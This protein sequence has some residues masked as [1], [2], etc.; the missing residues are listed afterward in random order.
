MKL[1]SLSLTLYKMRFYL[2][3]TIG[4]GR[5]CRIPYVPGL[6]R[7]LGVASGSALGAGCRARHASSTHTG[8]RRSDVDIGISCSASINSLYPYTKVL[9]ALLTLL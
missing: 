5:L 3:F 1:T 7:L 8:C 4:I 9:H 2:L 6:S